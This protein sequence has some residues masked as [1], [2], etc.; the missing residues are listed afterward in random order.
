MARVTVDEPLTMDPLMASLHELV[1]KNN[2]MQTELMQF[3]RQKSDFVPSCSDDDSD[4]IPK[5]SF[6][7][8]RKTYKHLYEEEASDNESTAAESS[9]DASFSSLGSFPPLQQEPQ[10]LRRVRFAMETD[11]LSFRPRMVVRYSSSPEPISPEEHEMIWY[12]QEDYRYFRKYSRKLA[13]VAAASRYSKEL[14][15]VLNVCEKATNQDVTHC[16]RIANTAVRGLE[17]AVSNNLTAKRKAA[18]HGVL[19]TQ[20]MYRGKQDVESIIY[21]TSRSF[22]RSA[23]LM[24]RIL[25]N[26]DYAVA[27][28]LK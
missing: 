14:E 24:A 3:H 23:R 4:G 5:D 27:R 19:E 18:I 6:A 28:S 2:E 1:D 13:S 7:L 20:S 10:R 8:N 26:G 12:N 25:G 21:S 15:E 16:S 17:I 9:S 11:H 22:S